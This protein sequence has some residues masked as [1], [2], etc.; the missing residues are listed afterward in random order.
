MYYEVC[1]AYIPTIAQ[2]RVEFY[3][4]YFTKYTK[5]AHMQPTV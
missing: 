4:M 1:R 3:I 5:T 2:A